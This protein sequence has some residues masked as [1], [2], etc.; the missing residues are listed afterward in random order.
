MCPFLDMVQNKNIK[1][2]KNVG[3]WG[4]SSCL[5]TSEDSPIDHQRHLHAYSLQSRNC[6]EFFVFSTIVN[7]LIC[8]YSQPVTEL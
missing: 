8:N 6:S 3:S 4:R 1:S 7:K 5:P 2:R